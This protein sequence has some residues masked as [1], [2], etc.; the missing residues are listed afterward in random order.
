MVEMIEKNYKSNSCEET[1]ELA[2]AL[3]K[4]LCPGQIVL[5]SG[6]LGITADITSPTFTIMN[7]YDGIL[8]HFDLYRL[9]SVDE[10]LGVG[11]EEELFGDKISLVEWPEIVGFNFFPKKAIKVT[12]RKINENERSIDINYNGK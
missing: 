12:I 8:N 5:L 10:L 3:A 11:A 7:S 4:R 9:K 6:D 2:N 1:K